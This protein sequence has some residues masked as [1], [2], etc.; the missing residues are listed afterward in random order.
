MDDQSKSQ[1]LALGTQTGTLFAITQS[2][3]FWQIQHKV[4]RRVMAQSIICAGSLWKSTRQITRWK[5][6]GTPP[7]LLFDCFRGPQNCIRFVAQRDLD[8]WKARLPPCISTP[9]ILSRAAARW[10]LDC[11][12]SR[13]LLDYVCR[14]SLGIGRPLT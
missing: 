14:F 6:P 12:F 2:L 3:L 10:T 4:H 1:P 8:K 7:A 13:I 5:K 9:T 11:L